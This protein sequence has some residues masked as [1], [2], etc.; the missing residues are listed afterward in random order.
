MPDQYTISST[1]S[2]QDVQDV[3]RLFGMY[4]ATLGVDL[5]YQNFD[6]ELSGLPGKYSAPAG[7]L[8]IARDARGNAVGCV[9][10]R[11]L[12]E[13]GSCEVKRLFTLPGTRGSG[14]GSSLARA[15]IEE[16]RSM[17]YGLVRL[18]TLPTMGAAIRLYEKLGFERSPAYYAPTPTGTIFMAKRL[19]SHLR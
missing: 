14:L 5:S 13:I 18:D 19:R 6:A 7:T 16:A 11:P 1:A 9:G 3:A 12:R 10:V 17:G 8:L 2:A 4:V 15:A